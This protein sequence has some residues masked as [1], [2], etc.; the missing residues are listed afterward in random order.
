L[1]VI[2]TLV[3]VVVRVCI[4]VYDCVR[5]FV[6]YIFAFWLFCRWLLLF[7]FVMVF[8]LVFAFVFDFCPLYLFTLVVVVVHVLLGVCIGVWV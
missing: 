8:V 6:C 3:F 2:F 7:V 1:Y 4:G 5:G